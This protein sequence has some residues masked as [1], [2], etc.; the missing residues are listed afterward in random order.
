[1]S[2]LWNSYKEVLNATYSEFEEALA[3]KHCFVKMKDGKWTRT[4]DIPHGAEHIRGRIYYV[5]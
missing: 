2:P 1:M 5:R 4:L 3:D